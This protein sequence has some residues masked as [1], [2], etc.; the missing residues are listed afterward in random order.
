MDLNINARPRRIL[1]VVALIA[2]AAYAF[3]ARLVT[4]FFRSN[5]PPSAVAGSR[6]EQIGRGSVD[7]VAEGLEVPWEIRF[8]PDGGILVTERR[9]SL[10][11]LSAGQRSSYSVPGVHQTG[12]GGLMGLALHPEFARNGLIYVCLTAQAAN[13]LE[14]RVERYRFGPDGLAERRVIF[15]GIPAASFHDGCR[16][17]FGPDGLLYIT[18]GDAGGADRA[19]DRSSPAG[20]ILRLTADGRIPEDNPFG[21]AVYTY[22]HRNPQGLT[23]DDGGRLWATEHGP[24][25]L[26]SGLDELNRIEAGGNYGWPVIQGSETGP[27]M[28]SPVLSSGPGYTWAPAGAAYHDGRIFFGGLRGEALYEVR[29]TGDRPPELRVH[30]HDDFGRIRAVR[31]GPEGMLYF[32]TSNRDGRGRRRPGDD[33][34]LRVDASLIGDP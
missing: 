23:F 10:V 7:V 25:G 33:R 19:Q 14:N 28:V 29:L 3:R 30:F 13:G 18:T 34:M 1:I 32:T 8:L 9:G 24:S 4:W 2:G 21:S 11:L 6:L 15:D 20:K 17:E 12:E 26:Q 16:L 31:F 5:R 22:G 27:N